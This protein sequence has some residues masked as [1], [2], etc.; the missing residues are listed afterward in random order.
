M[1][2]C[3]CERVEWSGV[4]VCESGVECVC[5]WSGVCVCE[6]GVVC[7][8]LKLVWLKGFQLLC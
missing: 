8:S 3:V 7:V 4:C 5:E 6:S 2:V 1:R